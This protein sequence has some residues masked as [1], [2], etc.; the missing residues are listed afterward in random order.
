MITLNEFLRSISKEIFVK[1]L[2]EFI[3]ELTLDMFI[4]TPIW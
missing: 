1:S 2:K 4:K 3:P